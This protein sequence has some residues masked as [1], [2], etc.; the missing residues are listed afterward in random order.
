MLK[1]VLN[2]KVWLLSLDLWKKQ[3]IKIALDSSLAS[4]S[5]L[6]AFLMRL[7]TTYFLYNIDTYIGILIGVV[8]ILST[9]AIRG[10]YNALTRYLS[11]DTIYSIV[12]GSSVSSIV[13][14]G[15]ILFLGLEIPRSVPLIYAFLVCFLTIG[16]RLLIRTLSQSFSSAGKE[17]VAIYGVGTAGVQLME[18]LQKS[19]TYNVCLFIDNNP[20]YKKQT[21]AGIPIKSLESAVQTFRLLSIKTMLLATSD[22]LDATRQR[23]FE[24][25]DDY[26]LKVKTIPSMASLIAGESEIS[27]LKD[28]KI[29]DLLGREPVEQDPQLMERN[30]SGK[31]VLI[32]GAGGSIG[33]ELCRQIIGL[34]PQ[35][36]I[37]LDIS[38]FAIY[39]LQQELNSNP[40]SK[41]IALIPIIGSIQSK[42][43]V[44]NIFDRFSVDT[45]FH[46][47]AYKHVPL[48]EQNI[49]QC[50]KNNVFGTLNLAELA[51]AAQVNNFILISTDKA[52]NP[53]NFMGASKRISE[54]ICQNL[55]S[56]N[57]KTCFTIVRFGNVLGSSGSVVPLFKKQIENGGP[58]T[59][60]HP[61]VTRYFM[62]ITEASQLV[63]QAGSISKGG[64]IFVLDMGAP[65]KVLD[66]AKKM[67][68]LAGLKPVFGEHRS[69]TNHEVLIE[70]SGL[71]P[72]EKLHEQLSSSPT[73][74]RTAHPRIMIV[75]EASMDKNK[76]QSMLSSANTAINDG[77]HQKLHAAIVSVCTGIS[78]IKKY[79]DI[80][81]D[82]GNV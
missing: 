33:S 71:R 80:L 74:T 75:R 38:E 56:A 42:S 55:T 60:T 10:L 47:A 2:S 65:I 17:N 28:I 63:I 64:D 37:M 61:D 53:S 31:V 57:T 82:H 29:E 12:I 3:L 26:P 67:I 69:I 45:V 43:V 58:V 22:D 19:P 30:I 27:Q 49:M 48:M 23:V 41:Y 35:K 8:S 36:I 18:A 40:K 52:V 9:F 81:I 44:K 1:L 32:T 78:D 6:L 13:L 16:L 24:L 66:L 54:I 77:N 4:A 70:V 21:L 51:I 14:I 7:E 39:A 68:A 46:A 25:L 73:L 34:A 50:I 72:G 62:T 20:K 15:T 11:A 5:L 79:R 76:M 59:L